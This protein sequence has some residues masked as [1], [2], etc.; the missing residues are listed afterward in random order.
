[1]N[2]LRIRWQTIG[3]PWLHTWDCKESPWLHIWDFEARV[4]FESWS[5]TYLQRVIGVG[6]AWQGN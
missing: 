6:L 1:M 2:M 3:L 5:K 4:G